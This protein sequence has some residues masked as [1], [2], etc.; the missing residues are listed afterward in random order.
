MM[1]IGVVQKVGIPGYTLGQNQTPVPW[2]QG[3]WLF[4]LGTLFFCK[5]V[6]SQ[7]PRARS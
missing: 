4:A 1:E 6:K 5:E 7:E 2:W 3:A